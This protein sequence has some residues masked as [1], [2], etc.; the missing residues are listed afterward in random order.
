ME[1]NLYTANNYKLT[2]SETCFDLQPLM[3]GAIAYDAGLTDN[4]PLN[5]TATS[6]CDNDYIL[7]GVSFRVCQND[8]TWSGSTPTCQGEFYN[9]CTVCVST[10]N[11]SHKPCVDQIFG[12]VCE[13]NIVMLRISHPIANTGPTNLPPTDPPPTTCSDLIAPTNGMISYNIG[14]VNLRPVDTV[15]TYTCVTGYTLNGDITRTCDSDGMW[16][17][18]A[19]TCQRKWYGLTGLNW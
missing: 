6:T 12:I 5:T 9:S 16:S 11:Y 15:A 19:T 13:D 7:I 17:G 14:T 3:N 4:R 1:L 10:N 2:I 8:G 18:S